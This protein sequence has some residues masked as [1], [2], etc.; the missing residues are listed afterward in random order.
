MA[1]VSTLSTADLALQLVAIDVFVFKQKSHVHVLI[2]VLL[3][4]LKTINKL[5][6]GNSFY[7]LQFN[8]I[9]ENKHKFVTQL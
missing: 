5:L 4:L 7:F 9:I 2:Y 1:L 3:V 6:F 8:Q